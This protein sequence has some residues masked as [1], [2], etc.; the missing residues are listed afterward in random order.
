MD[1][2]DSNGFKWLKVSLQVL[3]VIQL[4]RV[5]PREYRMTGY[6]WKPLHALRVLLDLGVKLQLGAIIC[7][8]VS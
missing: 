5:A 3:R 6:T 4:A 2:N 1:G 8:Q 7:I